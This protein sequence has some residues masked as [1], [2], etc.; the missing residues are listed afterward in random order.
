MKKTKVKV[1]FDL[2]IKKALSR[3]CKRHGKKIQQVVKETILQ[4][5]EDEIDL[6]AIKKHAHEKTVTFDE[7][8]ESLRVK[9]SRV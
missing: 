2:K 5:L 6:G 3:Y 7:V 4:T 1:T 8:S 9:S